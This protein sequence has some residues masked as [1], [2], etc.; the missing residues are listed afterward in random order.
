MKSLAKRLLVVMGVSLLTA[1]FGSEIVGEGGSSGSS[2]SSGGSNP[3]EC[4]IDADCAFRD[5]DNDICTRAAC[6]YGKCVERLVRNTPECECHAEEDCKYHKKE[7]NSVA[8]TDHKCVVTIT[9]AG[10]AL[11][12]KQGDCSKVTCDGTNGAGKKEP[13]LQD[14]PNDNNECTT[15]ACSATGAVQHTKLANGTACGNQGVCFDG[16]CVVCQPQN[17]TSCAGEGPGEP[18]NNSQSTPASMPQHKAFCAFGSGTDVDWYT[19]NAKDADFVTDILYF[20]FYS[21]APSIEV[22]AYAR[23]NSGTPTGCS[24]MNPGPNGSLGCCWS[25]PPNTLA[26]RWDMDCTGTSDDSGTI[27]VS[28]KMPGADTCEPYLMK[29]GY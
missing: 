21:Q 1:C 27:Y 11:E 14:L 9:P 7:C 17:P 5:K 6:E 24:P 4:S 12:Q 25:G 20:R 29:G 16:E 2:G 19:F 22:C 13:D 23:C 26:P 8:C 28:V 15:D 18:T 10:P 3:P